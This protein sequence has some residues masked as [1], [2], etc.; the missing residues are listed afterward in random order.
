MYVLDPSA[1]ARR[2]SVAKD[3]VVSTTRRAGS[4]AL[5]TWRDARNRAYGLGAELTGRLTRRP[6][7]DGALEQQVRARLG[8]LLRYPRLVDVWV[9]DGRVMLTGAV[10]ADEVERLVRHLRGMRGVEKVENQL[11]V[12]PDPA[13][14]PGAQSPIR[15]LPPGRRFD[16]MRRAWSPAGRAVAGAA[17]AALLLD[18]VRRGHVTDVV[19]STIGALVLVRAVR[20]EPLV[21]WSSPRTSASGHAGPTP[22]VRSPQLSWAAK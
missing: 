20:N 7:G 16:L 17:A 1:G 19:M 8:Q 10:A 11:D 5:T 9:E 18:P 13:E 12:Y 4:A 6:V 15:P 2:R 21:S 22:E 3:Q 14:L